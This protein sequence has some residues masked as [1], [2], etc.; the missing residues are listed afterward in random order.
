MMAADVQSGERRQYWFSLLALAIVLPAAIA[1]N[2][3]DSVSEWR[4]RNIRTPLAV[5]RGVTQH[6][7]G[8]QWQLTG[9][10]RLPAG[11]AESTLVVA[12]FEATVD[13]PQFLRD[14]LCQVV[15]QDDKGRRWQP[16][17]VPGRAVRQARPAAADKPRC[18]AIAKAE[19]GKTIAMA[20]SFT[21]PASAT[22][23]TLSVT[24]AAA[25]PEYLVF[26]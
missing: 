22:G 3:W 7:A 5:D 14:G 17:F 16:A 9:L 8:A 15:L 18:T 24:V 13:E 4:S 21:V 26:K 20:E 12:E 2:S 10:T 19:K 25:R 1:V 11:S 23:L 6:Y